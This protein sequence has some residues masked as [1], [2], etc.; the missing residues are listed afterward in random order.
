MTT[1][2]RALR[3]DRRRISRAPRSALDGSA[4]TRHGQLAVIAV[5]VAI[6]TS[7]W[8]CSQLSARAVGRIEHEI[9]HDAALREARFDRL[10]RGVRSPPRSAPRPAPAAVRAAWR[11]ARLAAARDRRRRAG[12]SCSRPRSR[13]ALLAG[14]M[15]SWRSTSSTSCDCA[16]VSSCDT[17]RT[18]RITSASITSSSVARKAATSMVGRSEM[19]PTVSDRMTRAPCGRSTAR[20]RRIERREQHV[21]GQHAAPAS[22]G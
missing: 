15:P 1:S 17:S 5:S 21:G 13:R 20:K 9:E 3:S 11:S 10:D 12:R 19:K 6:H 2:S 22:A 4:R 16:S 8:R 7:V 18:C 14:S